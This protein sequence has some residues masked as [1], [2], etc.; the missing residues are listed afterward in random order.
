MKK[1][2]KV[3]FIGI[4]L[5][6]LTGCGTSMFEKKKITNNAV[7]YFTNKYNIDKKD[8]KI[9]NNYLYGKNE[10]CL[11]SCGGNELIINYKNKKYTI[12]YNEDADF[13]GDNYQYDKVYEDLL[14]YLNNK[15]KLANEIEVNDLLEADVMGTSEKYNGNIKDYYNKIKNFYSNHKYVYSVDG[16]T[17]DSIHTWVNIWIEAKTPE[18]AKNLENR[19]FKEIVNELESLGVNYNIAISAD[20]D[21]NEYSAFYYYH[22]YDEYFYLTDNVDDK[23]NNCNRNQLQDGICY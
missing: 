21:D 23:Q 4:V 7:N 20:I 17:G 12:R 8:I 16:L 19:Y 15:F 13:F 9:I 18:E 11:D 5:I 10:S 14:N 2:L 6:T 22:V 3:I 1:K